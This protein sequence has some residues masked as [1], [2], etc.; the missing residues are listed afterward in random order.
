MSELIDQLIQSAE[1]FPQGLGNPLAAAGSLVAM[2]VVLAA[3]RTTFDHTGDKF[4]VQFPNPALLERAVIPDE[5]KN[6]RARLAGTLAMTAGAGFVALQLLGQPT[7]ES[8][9]LNHEASVVVVRDVSFSMINTKD[10][11]VSRSA[12][13]GTG[14]REASYAGRLSVIQSAAGAPR[15]VLPLGSNWKTRLDSAEKIQVD[16]NGGQMVPA[17]DLAE[18]LL[19]LSNHG[20]PEGTIVILS[21]GSI[22]QSPANVAVVA[23][24]LKHDGVAVKVVVPGTTNGEYKLSVTSQLVPAKASAE[25][26]AAFGANNIVEAKDA[27]SVV[28]AVKNALVDAGTTRKQ[29]PWEIPGAIGIAL[30]GGGLV[31]E[32]T[33]RIT[34]KV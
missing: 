14:L 26:F 4:A 19:P 22:D 28:K 21:D 34:R 17:I 23:Q 10:L 30:F 29:H 27:K 9:E 25:V 5:A 31:R 15:V 7:Y 1:H 20:K 2:G 6:R 13:V 32:I 33:Q 16:P 24:R 3:E 12:A 18:S 8:T 11:G